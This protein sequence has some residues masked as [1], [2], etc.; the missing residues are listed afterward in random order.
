[1][2]TTSAV[3]AV[4][5]ARAAAGTTLPSETVS[6]LV[7]ASW[8]D[9]ADRAARALTTELTA[10]EGTLARLGDVQGRLT[11]SRGRAA[12]TMIANRYRGA[13]ARAYRRC[14]QNILAEISHNP[15]AYLDTHTAPTGRPHFQ[16]PT[17][18]GTGTV[19]RSRTMVTEDPSVSAEH[20]AALA[21]VAVTRARKTLDEAR[22]LMDI[23][24]EHRARTADPEPGWEPDDHRFWAELLTYQAQDV[25]DSARAQLGAAQRFTTRARQDSR[26]EQ[27]SRPDAG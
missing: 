26:P 22:R 3:W 15:C 13:A 11:D 4:L 18:T 6:A 21:S 27:S 7:T 1:M 8:D 5:V 14:A 17:E 20:L 2:D 19:G 24:G 9:L 23:S 10:A 12:S 16:D 25:I